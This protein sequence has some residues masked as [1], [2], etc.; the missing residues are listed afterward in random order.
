MPGR[1]LKNHGRD[2]EASRRRLLEAGVKV[3]SERGLDGGSVSM[4]ARRRGSTGGCSTIISAAR[5]ASTARRSATSMQQLSSTEVE[6][7]DMVLAGGGTA[8]AADPGVVRLPRLAPAPRAA[9]DVGEPA[10]RQVGARR[11]PL[12]VQGAD[13]RG[14]ARRARPR[15]P[16][17]P[18]PRRRGREAVAHQLHGA[19][20]FLFLEPVHARP[21]AG[22][23][24]RRAGGPS[25]SASTTW[26]A[27]CSTAS[28][29]TDPDRSDGSDGQNPLVKGTAR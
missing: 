6:L 9:A 22:L 29:R 23:R 7:A 19:E 18:L 25:R 14:A 5:R 20:L 13:P 3:F 15:P 26:S 8:G 4:I 16:R 21:G 11:R 27:C 17:G 12:V 28:G 2:P 10:A 24:P 1:N